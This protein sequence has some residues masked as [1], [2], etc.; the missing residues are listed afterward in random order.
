VL[1][2]SDYYRPVESRQVSVLCE[3]E[4]PIRVVA[5]A[6]ETHFKV[7]KDLNPEIL[8]HHLAEG[9][10]VLRVPPEGAEGFEARF[11][12]ETAAFVEDS[13]RRIYVVQSGDNLSAIARRFDVPLAALL[14][15]NSIDP[16][17]PIHPGDRLVV[18]PRGGGHPE[19][20]GGPGER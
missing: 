8:G 2:E 17:R 4:T 6:A 15:W 20:D 18:Y 9:C 7:I 19:V 11:K 16:G 1:K 13:R 3:R 12:R 14:I 5:K 10:Y